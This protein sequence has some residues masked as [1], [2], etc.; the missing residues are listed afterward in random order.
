MATKATQQKETKL[1]FGLELPSPGQNVSN[2]L[3]HC[4]FAFL[5][6]KHCR[7][8]Q[9]FCDFFKSFFGLQM[10]DLAFLVS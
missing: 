1:A 8:G 4:L 5:V 3:I 6:F 9:F 10:H 2:T 7:H